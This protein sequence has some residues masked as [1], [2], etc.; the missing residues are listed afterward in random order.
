MGSLFVYAL[1]YG[2]AFV[3]GWAVRN[4]SDSP[5]GVTGKLVEAAQNA[6]ERLV[7]W[8]ALQRERLE[9]MLAEARAGNNQD[10]QRGQASQS[11]N[12]KREAQGQAED[13]GNAHHEYVE[14]VA[15]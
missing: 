7:R 3:A 10:V 8:T 1:G 12:D 11:D 13:N 5:Q 14:R 15:A 6:K 9:D 2:A 4:S